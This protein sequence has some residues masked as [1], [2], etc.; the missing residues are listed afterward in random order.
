MLA[1]HTVCAYHLGA[2]MLACLKM[3]ISDLF[4]FHIF[5]N[6]EWKISMILNSV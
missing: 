3:T 5:Y 4:L 2:K 6:P 1:Y